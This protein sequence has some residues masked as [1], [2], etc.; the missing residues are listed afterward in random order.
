M[1]HN[2]IECRAVVA[3][4]LGIGTAIAFPVLVGEK[5]VA[6]LEFFAN[7]VLQPEG[8]ITDVMADV[9][10]QVGRVVERAEFEEHLLTLAEEIQQGLSQ[11]LHD[12]VGQELT[13]LGLKAETLAEM[14]VTAK[15]PARELA[16]D[17]VAALER[18][19]DK[20][21]GLCWRMLPIE[22]EEGLLF[23]AL[24]QLAAATSRSSRMK[25][26]FARSHP[27]PVFDSQ[28][29]VHL[30]RIA[31]E[32]VANALRHSGAQRIR[33]TINQEHGETALS[34]EDDGKGLSTKSAR[35]EGMGLRTMRYCAGLIGGKLEIGRSIYGGTQVIC[36]VAPPPR[37]DA[38]IE[39]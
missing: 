27:D 16:A 13:G 34:I 20:I 26:E 25:C 9:G 31:Q 11:D 28:V 3:E 4:E 12:D 1:R 22:L 37:D 33:I 7:R 2:L 39:K 15:S 23:S 29:C 6:V 36:R 21:R 10:M 24:E 8:R 5:V 35:A 38:E 14:L 32:A 30:Y 17:I 18:T 19:H